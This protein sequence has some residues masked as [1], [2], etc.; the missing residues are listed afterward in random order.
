MIR[1]LSA[2]KS[3]VL[4]G[5][6][7]AD[8]YVDCRIMWNPFRDPVLGRLTGDAPEVQDWIKRENKPV[9]TAIVDL[10]DTG[11]KTRG[12]RNS[13]RNNSKPF[14]VC[15]FC[16]AGVHRSRGM[17]HVIG[18]ILKAGGEEVEVV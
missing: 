7:D 6:V 14:T 1:L 8:L 3:S 5:Q 2:A 9:I 4:G 16:L 18:S 13:G 17:K 12:T 11:L 10:I 15:F